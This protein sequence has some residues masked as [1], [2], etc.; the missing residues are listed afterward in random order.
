MDK[1]VQVN[2]EALARRQEEWATA[3]RWLDL[4]A[5]VAVALLLAVVAR[6]AL[7]VAGTWLAETL[8]GHGAPVQ[9]GAVCLISAAVWLMIIRLGGFRPAD[10]VMRDW[11]RYP[12]TWLGGVLGAMVFVVWPQGWQQL[13]GSALGEADWC[14]VL[15]ALAVIGPVGAGLAVFAESLTNGSCRACAR[16]GRDWVEDEAPITDPSQDR[17]G[18][19]SIAQRVVRLLREHEAHTVGVVGPYGSGKTCLLN[20]IVYHLRPDER[21]DEA[22]TWWRRR[23]AVMQRQVLDGHWYVCRVDAWGRGPERFAEQVLRM[24]VRTLGERVDVTSL[25]TLPAHYAAAMS[26]SGLAWGSVLGSLLSVGGDPVDCLGRLDAILAAVRGRMLILVEDLDRNSSEELLNDILPAL[27]DRVAKL[28]R[29]SFVLTIGAEWYD[30]LNL[31][32]IC[33]HRESVSGAGNA[34][35]AKELLEFRKSC[36]RKFPDD[37]DTVSADERKGR[38]GREDDSPML[39]YLV[40]GLTED[41]IK[42]LSS[43]LGNPRLM[44]HVMRRVSHAWDVLHGEIDFDD[45]LVTH[46]LQYTSPEAFAFVLSRL[47][48]LRNLA[49]GEKAPSGFDRKKALDEAWETACGGKDCTAARELIGVLF[50]QWGGRRG[51]VPQ[52]V[53][54]AEPTDYWRRAQTEQISDGESSD[55]DVLRAIRAWRGAPNGNVYDGRSLPLALLNVAG[56]GDKLEQLG[57]ELCNEDVHRIASG[58]FEIILQ[59]HGRTA[60]RDLSGAFTSLWR[61]SIRR[62][63]W[64]GHEEWVVTEFSKALPISL[65][66]ANDI[67][68]FWQ[69][70]DEDEARSARPHYELRQKTVTAARQLWESSPGALVNS[71]DATWSYSVRDFAVILSERA[72]GGEGFLPTDWTWLGDVLVRAANLAPD[73][74]LPQVAHLLVGPAASN[75]DEMSFKDKRGIQIFG[76]QFRAMAQMLAGSCDTSGLSRDAAR[77]VAFVQQKAREWVAEQC[78]I[79]TVTGSTDSINEPRPDGMERQA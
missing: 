43:L 7:S 56:L 28:R 13:W 66:F 2:Q 16:H 24:A 10:L 47:D 9:I 20:L 60:H 44:K 57:R 14:A 8:G 42:H 68:H 21:R 75:T 61:M 71:L 36:L 18:Y 37:V 40:D 45:L 19:D 35:A 69:C 74:I 73:V 23:L 39:A 3:F 64:D 1:N 76:D 51:G 38:L 55:Q 29:V 59:R 25:A 49:S 32:R 53:R 22:R 46:V 34:A 58:L 62:E 41:P 15:C 48:E 52:G 63:P 79:G 17:F 6:P 27:L 54:N 12:P 30:A 77:Q 72:N 78:S 50:P 4:C 65:R 33:E 5:T 31:M 11:W 26:G 70:T 67:H